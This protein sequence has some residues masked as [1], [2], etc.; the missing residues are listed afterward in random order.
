[1]NRDLEHGMD[2]LAD[3]FMRIFAADAD[4]IEAPDGMLDD[5]VSDIRKPIDRKVPLTRETTST[6]KRLTTQASQTPNS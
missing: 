4:K 1:M 6:L 2:W 3:Q 5:P